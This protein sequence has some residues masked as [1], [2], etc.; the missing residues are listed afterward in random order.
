MAAPTASD[1]AVDA[2]DLDRPPSGLG[3]LARPGRLAV[4]AVV[5]VAVGALP[6]VVAVIALGRTPW[7]PIGDLAQAALRMQSFWGDPPLVGPAGRIGTFGQ[8]GNHPGPLMFWA[9]WPVWRLLGGSGWAYEASVAVLAVGAYA[10]TVAAGLRHRGSRLALALALVGAVL[11][12]SFGASALTRPWNPY[13]PLVPYLAFV[14]LCWLAVCGRAKALPLAVAAGC[15]CVQ[16]HVGYAPAVVAGIGVA[17]VGL[18]VDVRRRGRAWRTPLV[19]VAVAVLTGVVLWIPPVIDQAIHDPGNLRIL[20]DTYRQ[21][22]G[23]VIGLGKGGRIFLTQLDPVGNWLLG[24]R[25]IEGS[26]IGGLVLL[27]AWAASVVLAWRRRHRDL[28]RLDLVVGVQLVFALYWAFRLDST[29]YLYL[30]EWFWVLT[31]LLVLAVA[32]TLGIDLAERRP[33]LAIDRRWPAAAAVGLVA[34]TVAFTWS[35]ARIEVP[36]RRYSETVAALVGPTEAGLDRSDTYLVNWVDPDALGGNGFG[37]FLQLD[38]AGYHVVATR[39]FSAAV[40][41]HRV[42]DAAHAD[43]VLTVVSGDD[44]IA[45]ARAL[46]DVREL[47]A[48][49]H[50]SPAQQAEYRKLQAQAIAQLRAAGRDDL[51]DSISGTIWTALIDPDVP[52]DAFATLSRMLELGQGTAVFESPAP[53]TL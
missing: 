11:L 43:A 36:D 51:A 23:H 22:T 2:P 14:V 42:G 8:Q 5:A 44:N 16:C 45:K 26:V 27:A 13:M 19:A 12:R 34:S 50:R 53:L 39:G 28:L 52:D 30:V 21:Q 40:E 33:T 32:W 24:T 29:R 3:P 31:G 7:Y 20:L 18:V 6:L 37:L 9:A 15:Y 41:P 4:V 47:A 17:T 38:R 46:P 10:A 49:D 48:T 35:A 1:G 25:R